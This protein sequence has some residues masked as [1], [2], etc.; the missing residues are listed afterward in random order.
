MVMNDDYIQTGR[1][2]I[3]KTHTF[4]IISM[5]NENADSISSHSKIF[6]LRVYGQYYTK[7]LHKIWIGAKTK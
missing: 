2:I 6:V 1:V 4:K 5:Y 7:I 3:V